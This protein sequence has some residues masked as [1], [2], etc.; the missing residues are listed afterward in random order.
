MCCHHHIII[1]V[2]VVVVI[3][4]SSR[5]IFR[6]RM[7]N[8]TLSPGTAE[9]RERSTLAT[10]AV[11]VRLPK[12]PSVSAEDRCSSNPPYVFVLVSVLVPSY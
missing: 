6:R 7:A 3:V 4:T 1:I 10:C 11:C 9:R 5:I 8:G 2:V 12:R